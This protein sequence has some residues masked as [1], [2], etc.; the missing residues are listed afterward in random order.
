ML[1]ITEG[2]G[3]PYIPLARKRVSLVFIKDSVQLCWYDSLPSIPYTGF[4]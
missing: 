3:M 1:I 4:F 2:Y